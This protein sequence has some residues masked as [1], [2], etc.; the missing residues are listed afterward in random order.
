MRILTYPDPIL[1]ERSS[2]IE[3]ID[4][5]IKKIANDMLLTMY[6]HKG[7]GLAAN[8]VGVTKRIIVF[9][10]KP[11]EVKGEG[12]VLINPVIVEIEMKG[13]ISGQEYCLSVPLFTYKSEVRRYKDIIVK[14]QNLEGNIVEIKT[15]GRLSI[16]LQ[17]EID[18]L[19]GVLYIDYLSK[20]KRDMHKKRLKKL[21][22]S[23]NSSS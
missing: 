14:G 22:Y 19:N 18:H 15:G 9:E 11:E 10:P 4:E 17:H 20:L 7:I 1:K 3:V 21:G 5:E 12:Q 2:H 6:E 8:Q 23:L 16:C 13:S